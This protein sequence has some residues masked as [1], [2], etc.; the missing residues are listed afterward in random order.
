MVSFF[1]ISCSFHCELFLFSLD[2]FPISWS[3]LPRIIIF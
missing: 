3:V 2:F 1:P